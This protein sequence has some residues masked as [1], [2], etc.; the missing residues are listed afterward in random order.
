M[1]VGCRH[2]AQSA[3]HPSP[4]PPSPL[5]GGHGGDGI[6][7]HSTRVATAEAAPLGTPDDNLALVSDLTEDSML[8]QLKQRFSER[9]IYT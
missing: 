1:L 2:F 5:A 8:E 6:D 3:V 4:P 9:H 7:G